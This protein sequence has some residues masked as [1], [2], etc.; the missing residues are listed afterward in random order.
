MRIDLDTPDL[1]NSGSAMVGISHRLST[2]QNVIMS[3]FRVI[4][5]RGRGPAASSNSP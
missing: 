5:L 2:F 3:S 1:V 4:L